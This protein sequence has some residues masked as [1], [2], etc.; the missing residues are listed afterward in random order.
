MC[1]YSQFF[2]SIFSPIAGKYRP[3]KPRIRTHFT[4]CLL[5]LKSSENHIRDI[6]DL[7][8]L[9]TT[10]PTAVKERLFSALKSLKTYIQSTT[11]DTHFENVIVLHIH[12]DFTDKLKL[13]N[14][15]T[16]LFKALNLVKNVS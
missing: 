9:L 10:A 2:W 6:S 4:Q 15:A 13:K 8:K 14:I 16:I 11:D 3:K 7:C 12:R 1:P 5:H